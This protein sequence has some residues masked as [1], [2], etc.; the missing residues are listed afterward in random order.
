MK[1]VPKVKY[2]DVSVPIPY[3]V[4]V[5][6]PV[7]TVVNKKVVVEEPP[8]YTC[9]KRFACRFVELATSTL[10]LL[11]EAV[12]LPPTDREPQCVPQNCQGER[13][14]GAALLAAKG[15]EDED[16]VQ[17]DTVPSA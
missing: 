11:P 2:H 7:P 14:Q 5:R 13:S 16:H 3:K 10:L 4:H 17:E 9:E 1:I 8:P 6:V 12:R 15:N